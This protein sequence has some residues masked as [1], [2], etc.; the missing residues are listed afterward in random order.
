MNQKIKRTL[1]TFAFVVYTALLGSLSFQKGKSVER[2]THKDDGI[3]LTVAGSKK[4]P[5]MD[6]TA[7]FGGDRITLRDVNRYGV[8][9]APE[10][11]LY[12]S[13]DN[14]DFASSVRYTLLDRDNPWEVYPMKFKV[15]SQET[16]D[17]KTSVKIALGKDKNYNISL[18]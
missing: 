3:V 2:L 16:E 15:L 6:I 5:M 17:E 18:Y 7:R 4:S 12:S 10:Q 1:G 11:S 8:N 14:E 9:L 13:Y